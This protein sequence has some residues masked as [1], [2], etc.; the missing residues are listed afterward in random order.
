MD[1][2][3]G[4]QHQPPVRQRLHRADASKSFAHQTLGAVPSYRP[5]DLAAGDEGYLPIGS[6]FQ[7]E[8]Y[9]TRARAF[10]AP[11]VD[12]IELPAVLEPR[13]HDRPRGTLK[14]ALFQGL[15]RL[16]P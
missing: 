9:Q 11:G 3:P 13:P 12:E 14:I 1:A 4:D 8:K 16:R 10:A 5:A 2:D 6:A 15:S 7:M